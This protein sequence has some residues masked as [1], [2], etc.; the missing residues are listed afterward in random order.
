MP[1]LPP[2][3]SPLTSVFNYVNIVLFATVSIYLFPKV[4][5]TYLNCQRKNNPSKIV[6]LSS[7]FPKQVSS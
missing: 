6:C 7:N 4:L 5:N 2:S 1:M 3:L